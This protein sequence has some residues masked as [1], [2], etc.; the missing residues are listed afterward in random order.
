VAA[1]AALIA[2][3]ALAADMPVKAPPPAPAPVYS[4]TGWYV[5]A[6]VGG[7]WGHR[8]VSFSSPAN[9][10]I[11]ADI[12]PPAQS[13]STSGVVGGLQLGYN[14]QLQPNWLIGFETDF[15]WSG[16]SGSSTVEHDF[17]GSRFLPFA[18]TVDEHVE[19]F[20][21]VRGRLGWLPWNNLLIYGTGG[22]AYGRLNH[23][24][25]LGGSFS[26]SVVNGPSWSC[27]NVT[28]TCFGGSSGNTA[29]GWTAGGGVEYALWQ[30]WSL[31]LEYLYVRLAS[32]GLTETALSVPHPELNNTPAS[33]NTNFSHTNFN[34]VRVGLNYQFH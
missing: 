12:V 28:T 11:L 16:M 21:T 24:G 23:T 14:W 5:G 9:D 30:Q 4:W 27:P 1:I 13:F 8:D 6:N 31:K 10:P 22:F 2:A 19:W 26:H 17:R 20:G 29:T 3:P 34:V 18:S 25:S 7:G 32:N 15:D 33:F